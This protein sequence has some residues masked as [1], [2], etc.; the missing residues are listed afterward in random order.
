MALIAPASQPASVVSA[1]AL[2]DTSARL[3]RAVSSV[4]ADLGTPGVMIVDAQS[5]G[6]VY[7]YR[8]DEP[9]VVASNVKLLTTAM[10][11][12]SLGPGYQFE[13]RLLARGDLENG[14]LTGSLAVVGDGDPNL[15]GRHFDGDSLAVFAAWG[16]SLRALGVREFDGDIHLVHGLFDDER[17]HPDWPR[18]QLSRWYE[19]PIE[20]L[21]FS[22]NCVLV[23]VTPALVAGREATVQVLPDVGSVVVQGSVVTTASRRLHKVAVDRDPGTSTIRVSGAILRGATPIETWVT[24]GDP[25]SFFGDAL[26]AGLERAGVRLRAKPQATT[27]LP[28]GPW[29][30]VAAFR[31]D[32]LSTLEVTNKRSQNL[33]AES[34]LKHLAARLCGE[35]SWRSG[36]RLMADFLAKLGL[37]ETYALADGSGMSRNNRLSARQLAVVLQHMYGTE[38][39]DEFMLTLPFSGS[40]DHGRWRSRLAEAPY[41]GNVIAKTGTLRGVSTLSGYVRGRSGR[42]YVFSILG[43]R[44]RSVWRA[45]RA[46]DAIVRAIVDFG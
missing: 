24:V 46:Q 29:L 43:N 44:V 31:S 34:L 3:G 1:S 9:R 22:D 39:R 10:A 36:I 38:L 12:E 15:S 6:E 4:R 7:G 17:V 20:A 27:R 42:V 11:L 21:S 13:T 26:V 19:A 16:R 35:G 25:V 23:R 33:Y 40:D 2:A 41:A 18:N 5:G 30:E 28:P 14:R 8:A 37:Q 32:L 45:R